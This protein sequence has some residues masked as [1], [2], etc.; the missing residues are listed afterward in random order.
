MIAA[1]PEDGH[2]LKESLKSITDY[3]TCQLCLKAD[4]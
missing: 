2:M 3:E 1:V 4:T